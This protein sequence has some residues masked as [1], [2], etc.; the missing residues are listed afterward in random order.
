MSRRTA[1][2]QCVALEE[3]AV[4]AAVL[5]SAAGANPAA[6]QGTVDS[7][8]SALGT[9]NGT[10]L[11]S[12]ESGRREINWDGVPDS[13]SAPNNL[14]ANFFNSNSPRGAVF[15]FQSGG[16]G[17]GFQVS[18]DAV[19]GTATP[20]EFG[21]LNAGYPGIFQTFSAERLFTQLND[22]TFVVDFFVPGTTM[23]ATVDAFGAVFA[24]VDN[25]GARAAI[26]FLG[27][28]GNNLGLFLATAADDGLSFLGV[29]FD[30]GER[31]S[32]VIIRTGSANAGTAD[33]DAAADVA[34]M[35]D[36]IYSEP[37]PVDGARDFGD[38]PDSYGTTEAANGARHL[39]VGIFLGT[40]R[41]TEADG[42]PSA[43]ATGDRPDEDGVQFLTP[44]IPGQQAQFNFTLTN[45]I[46]NNGGFVTM[47]IDY[48]RD[49]DFLDTGELALINRTSF[50]NQDNIFSRL[51][52]ADAVPGPTFARFRVTS[53]SLPGNASP[54]GTLPNG[55]VEDYAI[56]IG[57]PLIASGQPDGKADVFHSSG[58]APFATPQTGSVSPFGNVAVNVRTTTADVNGDGFDDSILVTGPGTPI[59]LAVVDGVN[60]STVLVAP[61]D[62][63]GGNFLGGGFV[64]A[65]DIDG[66]GRAEFAVTPDQGGGPRVTIF[67]LLANGTT[68]TK[69]NFF[70]IDDEAFRGGA[71][72][73]L[74]DINDD[75]TP[76]LLLAAGFGGGPRVAVFDG[77]AVLSNTRTKLVPDFFA[78]PEDAETLRNGVFAALGDINGD[79]FADLVF[80]GGPGG[81]PRVL[82]LSGQLLTSGSPNLFSQP[83]ANF[84]VAGNGN[85]RG[86]VRLAVKNADGDSKADLVVGS[87]AGS[88]A[89][90]RVYLGSNFLNTGEPGT[91]Q[92]ITV[93]GGLALADGV[94]V[95]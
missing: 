53:Q 18:A 47:F 41:D 77:D 61:F 66:D 46:N 74:G 73:A 28:T 5:F 11:G 78:F 83:I 91:F 25:Q 89:K 82:V 38:A 80:G 43:T 39:P 12:F 72:A 31:V 45:P 36:F 65:A 4:P 15:G 62:P 23:P 71:R 56:V 42:Q 86:G 44:L 95:G 59:R 14:P 52:P 75:G 70:G 13:A 55:E 90:V 26:Q 87:G 9:N 51:I 27:T 2:L 48:N 33:A 84:F 29:R 92:D 17:T 58:A 85:D 16:T 64:A 8:R 69:A 94:Y 37:Q 1:R 20:V 81:G 34:V 50:A 7:F 35:D 63:F 6:I 93:F 32:R 68:Q 60:N 21:N 19:N 76:D 10:T 3:R 54:L 79:G 49:G 22:T 30:A 24:D 40:A 57:S 67:S 88:P